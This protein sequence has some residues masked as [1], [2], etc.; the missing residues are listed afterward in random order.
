VSLL[1]PEYI[2]Y[3]FLVF[4]RVGGL[5]SSAP[6]FEQ[7]YIPKRVKLFLSILIAYGLSGLVPFPEN[8]P[9]TQPAALAYY[10]GIELLT[11]VVLGM[12]ARFVFFAI[13]FAGEFIGFQMAIS[14]SQVISPADGQSSNPISNILMMTFM[15]VFL[16][17][18]GHHQVFRA[19]AASFDVIPLTG[20]AL[21]GPGN[22]MLT[23]TG[24]LFVTAIRL[25]SPFMITI[26]LVDMS[27]GIF[28]RVAP[29]TEVFSMSLSLKLLVGILLSYIYIQ[30]FFPVIPG[31]L[32]RMS[33]DLL[34]MI[35]VLM[36]R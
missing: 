10:V 3:S 9:V 23:W 33:Q 18:D 26:F 19:L 36:P 35:E 14:I 32:T 12:A 30:N 6:F 15:M 21:A 17:L 4:V 28:A 27:L 11:G 20:A 8:L 5:I 13:R 16:I 34:D 31:M 1:D 29:Q 25:A 2:L 7:S 24:E 22:L